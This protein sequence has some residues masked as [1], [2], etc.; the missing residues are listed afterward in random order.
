MLEYIY[1]LQKFG[2]WKIR[3]NM[4]LEISRVPWSLFKFVGVW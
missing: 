4:Y 1:I 3:L 2:I